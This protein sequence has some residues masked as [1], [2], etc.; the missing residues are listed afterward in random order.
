[1][2]ICQAFLRSELRSYAENIQSNFRSSQPLYLT[3][4]QVEHRPCLLLV[5]FLRRFSSRDAPT[6]TVTSRRQRWTPAWN[7]TSPAWTV[8]VDLNCCAG[9]K[10][11]HVF[12]SNFPRCFH[13]LVCSMHIPH[14]TCICIHCSCQNL[15][16]ASNRQVTRRTLA[17]MVCTPR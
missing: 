17:S 11:M 16:V 10:G 5:P 15:L 12:C 2:G 14:R 4:K 6:S 3:L 8:N 13:R 9:D 1:M 7:Y